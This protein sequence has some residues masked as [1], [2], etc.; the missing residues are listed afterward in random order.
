MATKYT[1][2]NNKAV[3]EGISIS[4]TMFNLEVVETVYHLFGS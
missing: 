2:I 1:A 3:V 4:S